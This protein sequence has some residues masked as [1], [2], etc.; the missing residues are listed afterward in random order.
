MQV[1]E[2]AVEP[3]SVVEGGAWVGASIAEQMHML[4]GA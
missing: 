4:L 2:F 1:E 3:A